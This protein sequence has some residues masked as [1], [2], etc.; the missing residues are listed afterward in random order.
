MDK[1]KTEFKVTEGAEKS[2]MEK[3]IDELKARYEVTRREAILNERCNTIT[4]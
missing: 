2:E 3:A 1:N 4:P